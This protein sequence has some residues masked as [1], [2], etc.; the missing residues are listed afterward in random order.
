ME[1]DCDQILSL[2]HVG[3]HFRKSHPSTLIDLIV[4]GSLG[5]DFTFVPP[6]S[7]IIRA[8]KHSIDEGSTFLMAVQASL[9]VHRLFIIPVNFGNELIFGHSVR[10]RYSRDCIT[11]DM[12]GR[13]V[14]DL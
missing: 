14:G 13:S 11:A 3:N 1:R 2:T 8:G 9:S 6:R 4:D 10:T 12:Q 7:K 5:N